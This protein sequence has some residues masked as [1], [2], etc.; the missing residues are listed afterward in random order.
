MVQKLQ[1]QQSLSRKTS[2]GGRPKGSGGIP[3]PGLRPLMD[4]KGVTQARVEELCGVSAST[5]ND[6]VNGHRGA[7][8]RTIRRLSEGLAVEPE[9]LTT[10]P[11]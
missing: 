4:R 9:V 3:L 8:G 5:V 6:L 10:T 2:R 11:G 7:S 1:N